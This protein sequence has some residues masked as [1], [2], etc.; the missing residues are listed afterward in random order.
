MQ[1]GSTAIHGARVLAGPELSPV[2]DAV[3]VIEGERIADIGPADSVS[4]PPEVE[5][6]HASG[7]TLV[8]G[9]IDCHVHIGFY[10]PGEVLAGGVTTVR[11]LAWPPEEIWPLVERARHA[12]F[13]GPSILAAGQMLT[14]P[15][16]YPTRAPWAPAG[17]GLAVRDAAEARSAVA[18]TA[19]RGAAVI[20]VAL[21]AAV[22]PT[23]DPSVLEA[24]IDAAHDAGL[25]TTGHVYGLG[26]LDKALRAGLDELA[27]ILMSPEEIPNE[28]LST[29]VARGMVVVPT[30]AIFWDEARDI[31]IDNL[32]RFRSAG[33]RVVYGTD[34]GNEGPSPGI[35]AREVEGMLSA[36]F[37]PLELIA[38]ATVG[39]ASWLGLE[40]VGVLAAGKLADIVALEGDPLTD[41][42][43]LTRIASVWRR[44]LRIR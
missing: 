27:H 2:D 31:A 26:E 35:D 28:M 41:P 6:S 13:D 42:G 30:L 44:G 23:L 10:D 5:V 18:S 36:G 9:F 15:E 3:V 12:S 7:L 38:S 17:T 32:R 4:V 39:A 34:L 25:T 29:M 14:V 19:A 16:G 40:Q 43:A 20:K 24:I 8:P 37:T 33:G 22:G 11:D 21:N 1:A